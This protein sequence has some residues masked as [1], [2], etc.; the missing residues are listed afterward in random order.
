MGLRTAEGCQSAAFIIHDRGTVPKVVKH[1]RNH[2]ALSY[3]SLSKTT[4]LCSKV[5]V[6]RPGS[7][8]CWLHLCN[9][10]TVSLTEQRSRLAAQARYRSKQ[11][12]LP[13]ARLTC[14]SSSWVLGLEKQLTR[15]HERRLFFFR[16]FTTVSIV[17]VYHRITPVLWM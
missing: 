9:M 16:C 7:F 4:D 8:R 13:L 3:Q 17:F 12:A 6:A 11:G 5:D 1:K 14:S 10:V 2:I 15:S